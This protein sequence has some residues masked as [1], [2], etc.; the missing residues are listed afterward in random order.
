LSLLADLGAIVRR[1]AGKAAGEPTLHHT[2]RRGGECATE[3]RTPANWRGLRDL[4]GG[5]CQLLPQR[6]ACSNAWACSGLWAHHALR[7]LAS[8]TV[9]R[10]EVSRSS[11][12]RASSCRG[13]AADCR[14]AQRLKIFK[15]AHTHGFIRDS[16]LRRFSR[17]GT[18]PLD[19]FSFQALGAVAQGSLDFLLDHA[20]GNA[21]TL[22]DFQ[23]R[24][25][26]QAGGDEDLAAARRQLVEG[27]DQRLI[28]F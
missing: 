13:L 20:R 7:A 24:R 5:R 1:K 6:L 4:F 26:F 17:P 18:E 21:E 3:E 14:V 8:A 10:P 16:T 27:F 28:S 2:G 15:R 12:S 19:H 9:A 11:Q 25:F 23:V 22:G